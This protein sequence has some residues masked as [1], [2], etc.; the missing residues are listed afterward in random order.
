MYEI[1]MPPPSGLELAPSV[2]LARNDC[3]QLNQHHTCCGSQIRQ[4]IGWPARAL[5]GC[6]YLI[7]GLSAYG[8][9]PATG[10]YGIE[11]VGQT[12]GSEP[13]AATPVF[14]PAAGVYPS[15]QQVT[16]TDATPGATIYYTTN[17]TT[18]T[19]ASTSYTGAISVSSNETLEAIA[20][21]TGYTNSA[22]ATAAYTIAA[23]KPTFSVA[24]GTYTS[25]QTVA[26]TDTTPEAVIYFTTDGTV[27]SRSS[28]IYTTPITVSSTETIKAY[29]VASDY[30]LSE[31]GVAVYTIDAA[32]AVDLSWDA[33]S[34]S[35]VPIAGYNIYRSTGGSSAYQLL[36]SSVDTETTYVDNTV[37]SGLTY[38]YYVESVD[39]SGVQSAPSNQVS[40]TIPQ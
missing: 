21:E 27:P 23:A 16:I 20:V 13:A 14:S 31:E 1:S 5:I 30:G 36:N 34:D 35:P 38:D 19:T 15:A 24:S 6:C 32:N 37:Q 12:T 3:S 40:V 17:G 33:P 2:A 7:F 4:L 39:S 11:P 25:P 26:I 22:V 10:A 9:S 18:P 8:V 28:A 29:A